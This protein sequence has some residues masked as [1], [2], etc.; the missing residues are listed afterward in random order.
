MHVS[1]LYLKCDSRFREIEEDFPSNF[2]L[3]KL[4]ILKIN[5]NLMTSLLK[6]ANAKLNLFSM[7]LSKKYF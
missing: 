2:Q 4:M 3:S 5:K 6:I 7:D 1:L